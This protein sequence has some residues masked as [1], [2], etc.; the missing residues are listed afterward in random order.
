MTCD[1]YL[2]VGWT[3]YILTEFPAEV[4]APFKRGIMRMTLICIWWW[5]STSGVCL[6]CHYSLVHTEL[7]GLIYRAN[8]SIRKLFVLDRNTWNYTTVLK[9]F[10]FD[11]NTWIYITVSKLFVFDG[12]TWNH[13]TV[14]KLF[15]F[16]RNTWYDI[17]ACKIFKET[18]QKKTW[19]ESPLSND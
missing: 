3:K 8:S 11:R 4:Q 2:S 1:L 13:T 16:D 6:H 9:L 18:M 15:V 19:G 14:L 7:F 5:G 12:N 10:V 17:I